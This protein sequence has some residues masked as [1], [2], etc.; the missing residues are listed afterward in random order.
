VDHHHLWCNHHTTYDY[1]TQGAA[2]P[3]TAALNTLTVWQQLQRRKE[4]SQHPN[5]P[6]PEDLAAD[7][8][9]ALD[10]ASAYDAAFYLR[11]TPPSG[12]DCKNS[13]GQEVPAFCVEGSREQAILEAAEGIEP[14]PEK[15]LQAHVSL[16]LKV[17]LFCA[18]LAFTKWMKRFE[19]VKAIFMFSRWSAQKSTSKGGCKVILRIVLMPTAVDLSV[20]K[21]EFDVLDR[22]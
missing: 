18:L 15:L 22:V 2:E 20:C 19:L 13:M 8:V 14:W 11:H 12:I 17:C 1:T 5:W 16:V 6:V 21:I 3:L 10:K 4:D 9:E 7:V